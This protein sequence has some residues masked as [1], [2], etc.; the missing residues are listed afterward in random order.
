MKPTSKSRL[1]NKLGEGRGVGLVKVEWK[2][3]K[4]ERNEHMN[5]KII[6]R[7]FFDREVRIPSQFFLSSKRETGNKRGEVGCNGEE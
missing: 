2:N 7:D 3:K 1:G 6:N 4:T 5:M